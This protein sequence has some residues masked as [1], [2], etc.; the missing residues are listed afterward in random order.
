MSLSSLRLILYCGSST[1]MIIYFLISVCS[2]LCCLS[3]APL[4]RE[5]LHTYLFIISLLIH[6]STLI[7][8]SWLKRQRWEVHTALKWRWKISLLH[9]SW[10]A[11]LCKVLRICLPLIDSEFVMDFAANKKMTH[12]WSS[13]ELIVC[14]HHKFNLIIA[15]EKHFKVIEVA[16]CLWSTDTSRP[17]CY[18]LTI[19]NGDTLYSQWW[20]WLLFAVTFDW[21]STCSADICTKW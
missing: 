4:L 7:W 15:N 13:V 5:G 12:G 20:I 16:G 1:L 6:L 3:S 11:F 21:I 9:S 14:L 18:R 8:F 17:Y 19:C 10:S 2:S